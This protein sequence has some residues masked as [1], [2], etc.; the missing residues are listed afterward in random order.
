[1]RKTRLL[2]NGCPPLELTHNSRHNGNVSCGFETVDIYGVPVRCSHDT[3]DGHI[4]VRHSELSGLEHLAADTVGDPDMVYDSGRR[5]NRKLFYR[6][7]VQPLPF[8]D[9]YIL[10][11]VAYDYLPEGV[12]GVVVTCHPIN[13]VLEGNILAWQRRN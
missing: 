8:E 13:N 12:E 1:M 10:V 11:V 4:L 6:E 5:S 3:W 2:W 7:A 9:R